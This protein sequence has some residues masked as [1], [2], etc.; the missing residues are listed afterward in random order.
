[1]SATVS[2][3]KPP[4]YAIFEGGGA[5]GIT[6]VGALRAFRESYW[7]VGAA[8]ASAG[9]IIAALAA[10]GY[11]AD[12]LFDEVNGTDILTRN[13]TSPLGL[14][15]RKRWL[16]AAW[17]V[18]RLPATVALAFWALIALAVM[19]QTG[20]MTWWPLIIVPP[21][22][23]VVFLLF[24][25]TP[26][27]LRGGFLRTDAMQNQ[28]DRLLRDRLKALY[29]AR[30]INRRIGEYVT[31]ADMDPA[32]IQDACSLKII[33]TD[34]RRRRCGSMSVAMQRSPSSGRKA[35]PTASGTSC[36]AIRG[37]WSTAMQPS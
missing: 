34:A 23:L 6:H 31:F 21:V 26:V 14:L 10:V 13:G 36:K 17:I 35:L 5:K 29:R 7:L 9:A 28:L 24:L 12:D 4:A 18:S 15:G 16:L 33:V 30:G 22:V 20:H 37:I 2:T 1:M 32:V 25:L 3:G 8:G 11:Q 27:V 19:I